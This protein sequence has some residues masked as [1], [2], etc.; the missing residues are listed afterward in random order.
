MPL[1]LLLLLLLLPPP[2][3]LLGFAAAPTTRLGELS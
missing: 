1:L 3:P 2:S